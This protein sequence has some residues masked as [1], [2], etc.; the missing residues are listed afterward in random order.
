MFGYITIHADEMKIKEYKT[1]R[2]YYC[3][4]CRCLR[5]RYGINGQLTLSNDL[6]FVSILL[7]AL[8][9]TPEEIQRRMCVLHPGR[10]IEMCRNKF[11]EY[12][13]DMTVLLSYY[14]CLDHWEDNR[15]LAFLSEAQCLKGRVKRLRQKYPRQFRAVCSY[16]RNLRDAERTEEQDLDKVAGLTGEMLAEILVWQEDEWSAQLRKIGFYLGKFVY[17]MD[18]YEDLEKDLK[19]QNYNPLA[20]YAGNP[21]FEDY[22][23]EILTLMM[24]DCCREF[25]KLPILLHVDILRNI[26]YAGVWTRFEQVARKRMQEGKE[27]ESI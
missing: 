18:A 24:A 11:V 8:Y 20:S 5:K 9:E 23:R 25:E 22:C 7:T 6:T 13:A 17:L 27:H 2:S 16:V 3:G 21:G 15:N 10:K 14:Q 26:L 12:A 19:K 4:Q 1:Y